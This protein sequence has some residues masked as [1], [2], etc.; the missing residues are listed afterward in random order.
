MD[1]QQS[2]SPAY[3]STKNFCTCLIIAMLTLSGAGL[4]V[5]SHYVATSIPYINRIP[6]NQLGVTFGANEDTFAPNH[7]ATYVTGDH[8]QDYSILPSN[9][10][11]ITLNTGWVKQLRHTTMQ[12]TGQQIVLLLSDE[13]YLDVLLNW[14]VHV[15]LVSPLTLKNV[16][17]ISLDTVTHQILQHKQFHSIYVPRHYFIRPDLPATK[18]SHLWVI[19]LIIIRLLNS[20]NYDVLVFDSDAV[21]LRNIQPLLTQFAKSDIVSSSGSYPFDVHRKWGVPTLCMG[22]ILIRSSPKISR[23]Y[24]SPIHYI[25]CY[26]L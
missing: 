2:T 4:Y 25:N 19:R 6:R 1:T 16:L 17:I 22:V 3:F 7:T 18:F 13:R 11:P 26:Y 15:V 8:W 12:L 9:T 5:M 24:V 14:M 20:W 23:S 10:L 21:L